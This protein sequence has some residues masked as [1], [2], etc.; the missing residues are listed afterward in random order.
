MNGL[1]EQQG[2]Y[3]LRG[4][5]AALGRGIHAPAT[6]GK[7]RI[8][9]AQL[10]NTLRVAFTGVRIE[11]TGG[12]LPWQKK[13]QDQNVWLDYRVTIR[14]REGAEWREE[15]AA[16]GRMTGEEVR[17]WAEWFRAADG[18][19]GFPTQLGDLPNVP[20][21]RLWTPM[22]GANAEFLVWPEAT[23]HLAVMGL[24]TPE[25]DR[26]HHRF[27]VE[28]TANADTLRA[29]ADALLAEYEDMKARG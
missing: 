11:Q 15:I 5:A 12:F 6:I 24:F 16:E 2:V 9:M 25:E 1:P 17:F 27:A 28:T 8:T 29:F 3:A 4:G 26:P 14:A 7:A 23:G 13:A 22:A 19:K 18:V 20:V 10:G 21:A